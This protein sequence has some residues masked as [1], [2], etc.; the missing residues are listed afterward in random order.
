MVKEVNLLDSRFSFFNNGDALKVYVEREFEP[1][2][3][4]S[5]V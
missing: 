5:R 4:V 1:R 3:R 2:F